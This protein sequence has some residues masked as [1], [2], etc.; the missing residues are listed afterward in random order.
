[1]GSLIDPRWH[2]I[3]ILAVIGFASSSTVAYETSFFAGVSCLAAALFVTFVGAWLQSDRHAEIDHFG[4]RYS[5]AM[6]RVAE[7]PAYDETKNA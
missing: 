7:Y 5:E 2:S 6:L 1:M 3:Y 4:G